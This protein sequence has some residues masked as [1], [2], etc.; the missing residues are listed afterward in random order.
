MSERWVNISKMSAE[1]DSVCDEQSFSVR[2]VTPDTLDR[3]IGSKEFQ[4]FLNKKINGWIVGTFLT[5]VRLHGSANDEKLRELLNTAK[6]SEGRDRL[7]AS[8]IISAVPGA[9][10]LSILKRIEPEHYHRSSRHCH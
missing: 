5:N 7:A 3:I 6:T 10:W 4:S 2:G 8:I 9:Q 1:V